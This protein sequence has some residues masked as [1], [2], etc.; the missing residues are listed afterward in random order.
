M[1]IQHEKEVLAFDNM[2]SLMEKV[3]KECPW[4]ASQTNESLRTL[5]IEEL[6]ELSQAILDKNDKEICKELGDVLMH[7]VFYALIGKEKKAFDICDVL[8]L[9]SEKLIRRHPHVFSNNKVETADDVEKNWERIKLKEGNRSTFAGVPQ[10]LPALIKA[11]RLQ[12][13]A[14]GIGFDWKCKKDVWEK[15]LEEIKELQEEENKANNKQRIE[16][17]FGDLMFALINYARFLEINPDT[18]LEMANR[19][20]KNR[21]EYMESKAKHNGKPLQ[22]MNLEEMETLWQESKKTL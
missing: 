5:T 20:F 16:E 7:V 22:D 6:Y 18:A 12:D 1:N 10:T 8:N 11:Y 4:D 21:F 13:K 9:L 2:L 17:E 14:K 3:R 15:V 19:K